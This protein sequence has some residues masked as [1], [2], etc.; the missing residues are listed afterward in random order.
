[1]YLPRINQAINIFVEGWNNHGIRTAG[2]HSPRQLFVSGALALQHS[3]LASVDF[4][5]TVDLSYG[6]DYQS[7]TPL[8]EDP[9]I[10]VP[11]NRLSLPPET[12][13]RLQET[14]NPL[15]HSDNHG[16]ELYEQALSIVTQ[17]A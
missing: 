11:E 16:I 6:I 14:V 7:P 9:G 13:S 2:R 4:L 1:M 5:Q 10:V 15:A 12:L 8:E 3:G 17:N